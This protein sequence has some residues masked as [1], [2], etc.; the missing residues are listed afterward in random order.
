MT[1]E[2]RARAL[3]NSP[4]GCAL[5]LDVFQNRHLP[6]EHFAEP[7]VSFWLAASA[8]DFMDPYA[9]ANGGMNQRNALR[10][11]QAHED[12]ALS[13]VSHRAFAWWWE[14]VDL[15]NQV[16]SSPRMP[17]GNLNADHNPSRDPLKLFD[18]DSWR[19]PSGPWDER[20]LDPLPTS[21]QQTST[22]RGGT[23][24]EVT[25]FAITSADHISAFPLAVW[26]LEF[27]QGVRVREINHPTDWH[28]LCLEFPR[29]APDGRLAPDWVRVA[30]SWDGVHL[31]LGGMLSCEQARYERDGEWSML[32]YWHAEQT[33]W[34]RK[35]PITA[36]RLPDARRSDHW[37][38]LQRY[39]YDGY[40]PRTGEPLAKD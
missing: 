40:D 11:A 34:L 35:L 33:H 20:D 25:A 21:G 29:I 19:K 31:T 27:G 3:L 12:L 1:H 32:Q 18:A 7:K 37:Q 22:L 9:D 8:M 38:Q 15:A 26:R 4:V 6:L 28:E 16:W 13:I 5:I 2:T 23:T 17:G 36:A 30:E 10:D 24:S 14:P 39:P